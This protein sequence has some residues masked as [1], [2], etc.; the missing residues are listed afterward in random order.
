MGA[1]DYIRK[2]FSLDELLA[3]MEVILRRVKGAEATIQSTYQIGKFFFDTQTQTI[4]IDNGEPISLTTKENELLALLCA[5]A[6][7]TLE[8]SFALKKIWENDNYFNA[9]SMDVY[10]TKLRKILKEDPTVEIK[11]VHGKG[12]K[13]ITTLS[14]DA[15]EKPTK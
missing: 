8:R 13:L 15:E 12:Y 3:R 7:Q 4:T 10:I 1:D 11:N 5:Y 14:E 2:P 9:R 6:N